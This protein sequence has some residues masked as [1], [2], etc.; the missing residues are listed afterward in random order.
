ML[1][2]TNQAVAI[3]P[4]YTVL[5]EYLF[6]LAPI[7]L[8]VP[9]FRKLKEAFW[10]TEW[11]SPS[12]LTHEKG[13][14]F[15]LKVIPN[16]DGSGKNSHV[17]VFVYL[18]KGEFDNDLVWPFEGRV[19]IELLNWRA[20][21][22]H[23]LT[24][25]NLN[26]HSDPDGSI[27]SRVYKK[28]Y[29][30][31]GL[32][33]QCFISHSSLLCNPDTST[34][35][36]QDD[37][38]RLRVVDVAVYSTPL[39][40]KTR[41]WQDL[42]TATQSVCD[43]TLTEFT[44]RKQFNNVYYSPPF[45]SHPHGYKL[46]LRVCANGDGRG[47]DTHISIFACLMRGD[48]DNNLQ[49]PFE[50]GIVVELLNWRENNLHY[51][52]N[53]IDLNRQNDPDGS[54]TSRVTEGE[55]APKPWGIVRF[56]SH[57]SLLYNADTNTE[58][59]Q[60]NCLHLRVV[61]VAVY[62]TPLLSK[63]P[64]WQ[65]PHT[66][67][68]SVCDLTL[69]EFTKRKQFNNVY[70]S[71]PFY[72]HTN[73]YKLCI[74]VYANGNGVGKDTHVSIFA[75]LMRG[76]YDNDLQWPF[77]CDIVIEVLNW[78]EDNYHYR[79]NTISLNNHTQPDGIYTNRVTVG[80]YSGSGWGDD[81]FSHSL[82]YNPDTNTEY[83]QDD[84]LHLSVVDVAVY[85]TPL[86]CKTPSWQDPHTATQSVCD[87]TLAEFTKRKLFNNNYYSPPFYSHTNGYKMLLKVCV[88]GCRNAKGTRVSVYVSLLKG[89]YDSNLDWPFKGVVI[90]ELTNWKN[91]KDHLSH[92]IVFNEQTD[93]VCSSRVTE[94]YLTDIGWNGSDDAFPHSSLLYNP[95]TNT[96]YLHD[97]C[98]QFRV[99]EV[100]VNK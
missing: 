87:F 76:E 45:Y 61:D 98:L 91:D 83:L 73:G 69:T 58:Y 65:D 19:V 7:E 9:D 5:P 84:C 60:D 53:T 39:L 74:I 17:S 26:R 12:L 28:E 79:G 95:V 10:Y 94:E 24:T 63:I 77:E 21:K 15:C 37:C 27:T 47:K 66:A 62:S 8:V 64:S 71:P 92:T 44:K 59:L 51:R 29:A 25:V 85:F 42:H 3:T 36:L 90:V 6:N 96:E 70:Y 88:N 82:L 93:H 43:F 23:L 35:Y 2:E 52:G 67:T 38:L 80:E 97:D 33:R 31:N 46:C 48:Y 18:M 11:Y 81:L 89:E 78:K 55:Y 30:P 75:N 32:G 50:S 49:W 41:S 14:K 57:S 54:I 40:S 22:N 56:I 86:L 4:A 1:K 99:R 16:G 68:Q 100:R 20:D 72:S 34:E 13:Y